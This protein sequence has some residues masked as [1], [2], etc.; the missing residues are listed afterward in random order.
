VTTALEVEAACQDSQGRL[1]GALLG[2]PGG[3]E[4]VDPLPLELRRSFVESR[5]F[6]ENKLGLLRILHELEDVNALPA[7]GRAGASP[8]HSR[9]LRVPS[10]GSNPGEILRLWL[11]FLRPAIPRN[12]PLMLI[13]RNGVDWLDVVVGEP[14]GQEFFCLQASTQALPLSTL[15]PY[16]LKPELSTKLQNLTAAFLGAPPAVS[17]GSQ[18][19]PPMTTPSGATPQ[20]RPAKRSWLKLPVILA[21]GAG[22]LLLSS[23]WFLR[24]SEGPAT[25]SGGASEVAVTTAAVTRTNI[26]SQTPVVPASQQK[27]DQLLQQADAALQAGQYQVAA[28]AAK[29]ALAIQT[30]NARASTIQ[31]EA[32]AKLADLAKA[33]QQ[34]YDYQAAIQQSR[35]AFD[36]KEYSN[37]LAQAQSALAQKPGD[38]NALDLAQQAYAK[39]A[40]LARAQQQ[41]SDYQAA[42]QGAQAAF[43]Q[44]DYSNVLA[45]AQLALVKKPGDAKALDLQ[46]QAQA[47][48][49]NLAQAQQKDTDFQTAMQHAQTAFAAGDYSNALAQAQMALEN[50]PGEAQAEALR[51]QAQTKLSGQ[52]QAQQQ[53]SDYQ[54]AMQGAQMAFDGKDYSNAVAQAQAA[55]GKRPGDPK[56]QDLLKL[57]EQQKA[58]EEKSLQEQQQFDALLAAANQSFS[59]KSYDA[60]V[61]NVM[62]A[63]KLRPESTIARALM[64]SAQTEMNYAGVVQAGQAALARKDLVAARQ[65]VAKA[66]S[67]K[68][69]GDEAKKL[70]ADIE[71]SG[72]ADLAAQNN[73]KRVQ[74][75]DDQLEAYEV[76]LKLVKPADAKSNLARSREIR[77]EAGEF[78]GAE[79]GEARDQLNGEV[80][81]CERILKGLN[82]L[83]DRRAAVIAKLRKAIEDHS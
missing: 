5:Q 69:D 61:S 70:Q 20:A 76:V 63:L 77:N 6:D 75:V 27:F 23:L 82:Q 24:K 74:A 10:I 36:G 25:R 72:D 66:L 29:A 3:R 15:I 39:L 44:Q 60:T 46:Q 11:E 12:T 14:S 41:E 38:T 79:L 55:L 42:L 16:E 64:D 8:G 22:V 49:G 37:A 9:H 56:A 71:H 58:S 21:V 52:A 43:A 83:D 48:L 47:K 13:L 35:V 65:Q 57:A 30:D 45:E 4:D 80:G 1:R 18:A 67:I 68:S 2:T 32:E 51:Q 59:Q 50:K 62:A 54:V 73:L 33:Q 26:A 28:D 53:E 81:K 7:K 17:G 40:D 19:P 78:D 31:K 34:Q